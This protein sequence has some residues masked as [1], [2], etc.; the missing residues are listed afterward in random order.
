MEIDSDL[1]DTGLGTDSICSSASTTFTT[2]LEE[3]GT[4]PS[5]EEVGNSSKRKRKKIIG[6]EDDHIPLPNPFPLP[7]HYQAD[8]EV[9]M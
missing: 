7:K 6:T 1:T 2:G 4:N 3:K 8:V 9:G 5:I